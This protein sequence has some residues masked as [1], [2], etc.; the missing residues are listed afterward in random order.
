MIH[1]KAYLKI[2][3]YIKEYTF[4]MFTVGLATYYF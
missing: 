3:L 2:Q 4:L 1:N